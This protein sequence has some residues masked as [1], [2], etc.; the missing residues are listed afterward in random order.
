MSAPDSCC[1][2][3][4]STGVINFRLQYNDEIAEPAP[5]AYPLTKGNHQY[6]ANIQIHAEST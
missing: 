5:N 4:P 3:F 1:H 2:A 6:R